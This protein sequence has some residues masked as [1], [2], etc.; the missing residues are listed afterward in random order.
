M[1]AQKVQG[2]TTF[3][4]IDELIYNYLVER[5]WHNLSARSLAVSIS[6]EANEL[7]EH[8]QWSEKPVGTKDE[9]AAELADI[10]NYVF[11]FAQVNG[12][13]IAEAVR[14][15]LEKTSLKY[16]AHEFKGKSEDEERTA[17]IAA[18]KRYKKEG[19]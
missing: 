17:W 19:L 9:L 2:N 16:P 6:L 10:V 11:E 5:D 1:P 3:A 8:Y 12:I 7:L 13:D 4:E 14:T 15:K 18:K